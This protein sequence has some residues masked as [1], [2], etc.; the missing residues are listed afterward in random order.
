MKK[1]PLV[2]LSIPFQR[3]IRSH[4]SP[5]MLKGFVAKFDV[6]IISPNAYQK[7]FQEHYQIN[8]VFFLNSPSQ[9]LSY[10]KKKFLVVSNYLRTLGYYYKYKSEI[11]FYWS[12]RNLI[13]K[14][15]GED[16]SVKYSKRFLTYIL[17]FIGS[18][19]SVWRFFDNLHGFWTYSFV[20][21]HEFTKEYDNVVLIQASSWGFQDETLG[22]WARKKKWKTIF[23][24]YTTD[25]LF[26]N[27]WLLC[28]YDKIC[29]QGEAELLFTSKFHSISNSKIIKLGSIYGYFIRM[30]KQK[31]NNND[32]HFDTDREFKI[33]YAGSDSIYYPIEDEFYCL[34]LILEGISNSKLK[35]VTV[36]YRPLCNNQELREQILKRYS[37]S[38]NLT[39]SFADPNIFE[40][41]NFGV[42]CWEDLIT[43]QVKSIQNVDLLITAGITSL[44]LDCAYLGIPSIVVHIHMNEFY[45][46]R[47]INLMLNKDNRMIIN[48][49]IPIVLSEANLTDKIF[50]L[51][52]DKQEKENIVQGILKDW[53][54]VNDDILK[55]LEK[56]VLEL[57][58]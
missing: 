2:I 51:L 56:V 41:Y 33:L 49:S 54:N 47:K 58:Q 17:G 16:I 39:I 1:R 55:D 24:P 11:P 15:N 29:V 23:V 20:G 5:I 52:N 53:D 37:N 4:L 13:F 45:E 18:I 50:F 28:K 38:E 14:E 26:A 6:L 27:G 10:I 43:D 57:L 48:S 46:K 19:P 7:T 12:T 3:L 35:N 32:S 9:K 42:K 22:Y 25:Q 34:N 8:N 40:V 36:L 21:L 30:V 44:S 31:F